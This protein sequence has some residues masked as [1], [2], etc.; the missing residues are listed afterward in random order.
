MERIGTTSFESRYNIPEVYA[1][2]QIRVHLNPTTNIKQQGCTKPWF[3]KDSLFWKW[4]PRRKSGEMEDKGGLVVNK[5]TERKVNA[6]EKRGSA[7]IAVPSNL[8]G[9]HCA[10]S[11]RQE[12]HVPVLNYSHWPLRVTWRITVFLIGCA[13]RPARCSLTWPRGN[14][15]LAGCQLGAL[16]Q[17]VLGFCT[18]AGDSG[19][20][21]MTNRENNQPSSPRGRWDLTL[22]VTCTI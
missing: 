16:L 2:E 10:Q 13:F 17:R 5:A 11:L 6:L 7:L 1:D 4:V 18:S 3:W 15:S 22:L 14:F 8:Q 20:G 21:L 19:A 12:S 9:A